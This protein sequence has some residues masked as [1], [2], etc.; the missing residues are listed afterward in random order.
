MRA[1]RRIPGASMR[2]SLL[3]CLSIKMASL[4]FCISALTSRLPSLRALGQKLTKLMKRLQAAYDLVRTPWEPL[5]RAAMAHK[6]DEEVSLVEEGH[7]LHAQGGVGD[8]SGAVPLPPPTL[9]REEKRKS[10]FCAAL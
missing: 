1:S 4:F 8:E 10:P 3:I 2:F 9:G 6:D 7:D 5:P